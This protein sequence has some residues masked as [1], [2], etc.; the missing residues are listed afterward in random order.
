MANNLYLN[1]TMEDVI[2]EAS[3]YFSVISVTGPRQ[4]GKSTLL[5]HLFPDIPRYSMKDVNV[6]EFTEHD[7]VAFLHQHPKGMFIDEVQK[8]PPLLEYIQGIVDDNP[9]CRFL[10]TGSSNFELLHGL[11][12]SLP[13]RAGVYELLPMTYH[14]SE[15][16]MS[17]K[18]LDEFLYN[19]LY[20]AICAEKNKARLFYPSYVKTYLERDVRDLLKIKDQMQFMKFMKLCAARVGSIFN[21]SELAGQIGVDSKT[22]T[23]WLSVLQASY[24]VTLLPPYY[25]NI[26]K[27]L[28][29]SPKLYFNDP[30]LACYLLDIESPRQLAR[31]KMRGAIFENYVVME[32]IKHRYNRGLLNGVYFYRDSNQNEVDILLKEEGEI[33]AIE[34]KSSMTYHT[35]FE[36]DIS[37][38]SDWIKT[39]VVKK[40][41]VYTGD[42]ENTT[43][44]IKVLNYRHLQHHLPSPLQ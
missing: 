31:D 21:A 36:A 19:G 29:K 33:T 16:T 20:P 35:S 39:P 44:D 3:Q 18:P 32:V 41:V 12:E 11:C 42:F 10:L 6:R 9:D 23:N 13:G 30:G 43:S 8:V 7:P 38:L 27:R 26:S 28:V 22:I 37:H 1:R 4:S 34:V 25:E 24:L 5:K 15:S 17:A 2:K 14:E 40:M